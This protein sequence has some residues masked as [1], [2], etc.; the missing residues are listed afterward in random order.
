MKLSA[1]L[2]ITFIDILMS[3]DIYLNIN[4]EPIRFQN[5]HFI[6]FCIRLY[7]FFFDL[8]T[9]VCSKVQSALKGA[10]RIITTLDFLVQNLVLL[11]QKLLH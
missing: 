2:Y 10:E 1:I 3:I 4:L 11:L 8:F 9:S 7:K 5:R 6:C